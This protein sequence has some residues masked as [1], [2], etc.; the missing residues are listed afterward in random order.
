MYNQEQTLCA[1]KPMS[2]GFPVHRVG[3]ELWIP[4]TKG[5]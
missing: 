5:Q 3:N 1:G 2:S 4:Y